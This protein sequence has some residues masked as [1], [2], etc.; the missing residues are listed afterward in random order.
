MCLPGDS[1][2]IISAQRLAVTPANQ[3]GAIISVL[4]LVLFIIY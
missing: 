1:S 3:G 2:V 4:G